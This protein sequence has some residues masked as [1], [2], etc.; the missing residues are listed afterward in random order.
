M[1]KYGNGTQKISI[2]GSRLL[3]YINDKIFDEI[4]L[5][6]IEVMLY[7]F[8]D[9]GI[10]FRAKTLN[11]YKYKYFYDRK[12]DVRYRVDNLSSFCDTLKVNNIRCI[13]DFGQYGASYEGIKNVQCT[14]IEYC[15][16]EKQFLLTLS[17]DEEGNIFLNHGSF[18]RVRYE[19]IN[20]DNLDI[21]NE[22]LS[23]KT[24]EKKQTNKA[25]KGVYIIDKKLTCN[26]G[27][28]LVSIDL[29]GCNNSATIFSDTEIFYSFDEKEI[30]AKIIEL[31][32]KKYDA[33]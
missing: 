23:K 7:N 1:L 33:R 16:K 31:F 5:N 22:I 6:D 8:D 12:Y 32:N 25:F 14:I 29:S 13:P 21:E 11:R 18:D 2:K 17:M 4:P 26:Q 19:Y 10:Y 28:C 24:S 15:L 27:Y 9:Y 3:F 30:K 20:L